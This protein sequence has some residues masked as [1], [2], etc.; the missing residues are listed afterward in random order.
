M[1]VNVSY[2]VEV[3]NWF[4]IPKEFEFFFTKDEDDWTDDEWDAYVRADAE[5]IKARM[6]AERDR[7]RQSN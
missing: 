1:K 2:L 4:D 6:K 5:R 3:N 7:L